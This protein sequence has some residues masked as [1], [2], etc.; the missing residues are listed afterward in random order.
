[1]RSG[2]TSV[3]AI[4]A[5]LGL[6]TVSMGAS[7]HSEGFET[8]MG[9]WSSYQSELSRVYQ[10]STGISPAS[11][12]YHLELTDP[13]N[14]P[15]DYY[16]G[17]YSFLGG[18]RTTLGANWSSSLQIYI[19]LDDPM[20]AAGTYGF[21]ISQAMY[22]VG[23]DHEQDN[24][25]HVGAADPNESGSNGLYVNASHNTDFELK[26]GKLTRPSQP[27]GSAEAPGMF[28]QSGWY[29]FGWQFSSA[30]SDV[31]VA[32]SVVDAAGNPLWS[33]DWVTEAYSPSEAG[34]NGYMWINYADATRLAI[35]NASVSTP[36]AA[37]PEPMTMLAFGSAVA[38]LGGY[39]RRR[40]RA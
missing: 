23:N 18:S 14:L 37:I 30:G 32:F 31:T 27:Y 15:Q 12:D 5:V 16:S 2:I 36:E 22:N 38:G 21:D 10:G 26:P 34:G 40:R 28:T 24:I 7:L 25:F 35:D 3:L 1:M 33:A 8:D 4:S 13:A 9:G 39:I 6:A 20:I 19:D 29:T 11:G 17:A